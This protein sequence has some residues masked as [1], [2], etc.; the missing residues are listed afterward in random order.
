MVSADCETCWSVVH[1]WWKSRKTS[2]KYGR[3][4]LLNVVM[5]EI[6]RSCQNYIFGPVKYEKFLKWKC[7]HVLVKKFIALQRSYFPNS[8]PKHWP[9]GHVFCINLLCWILFMMLWYGNACWITGPWWVNP[10]ITSG[11]PMFLSQKVIQQSS[12]RSFETPWHFQ[13]LDWQYKIS[14][15]CWKPGSSKRQGNSNP[16]VDLLQ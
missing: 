14:P 16:G 9:G 4:N 13:K 10:L 12:W 5:F 6:L 11:F 15:V 7:I 2:E 3:T 8:F 1:G